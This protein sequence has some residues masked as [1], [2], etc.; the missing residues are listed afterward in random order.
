MTDEEMI[1]IP[2]RLLYDLMDAADAV[3]EDI[4]GPGGKWLERSNE[5]IRDYQNMP[6]DPIEE[7]GP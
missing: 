3:A 6:P 1:T 7:L 4:G 2:S 5:A